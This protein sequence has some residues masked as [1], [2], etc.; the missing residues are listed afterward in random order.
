MSIETLKGKAKTYYISREYIDSKE[1]GRIEFVAKF[2]IERI[3]EL[4]LDDFVLGT[5][6]ESFCYWLEFKKIGGKVILFG[7]GGG[8]ASKFG[9]YKSKDGSYQIGHGEEKKTLSGKELEEYFFSIKNIIK[10]AI[11]YVSENRISEIKKMKMPFDNIVLL[12]ILSIYYPEKFITIGASNVLID[13]AK[14]I[15]LQDIELGYNNLI[16]INYECKKAIDAIPEFKDWSYEKIGTF[17]WDH[18]GNKDTIYY[19]LVGAYWDGSEPDDQ[20]T[21]FLENGIWENG[22]DDKFKEEVNAVP[23]GSKI[24]I[25]A[26]FTKEKTKS[27][28][29]IKAIGTV[30]E[31][32]RDGKKLIVKWDDNFKP[33]EVDFSGGYWST[34]KKVTNK[35]H[36]NAIFHSK[37]YIPENNNF[38]QQLIMFLEQAKTDNLRTNNYVSQYLGT[39]VKVSFGI[40]GKAK[41]PWISFLKGDNTTSKGI[42]PVYLYYKEVERLI[43]AYGISE[44]NTPMLSWNVPDKK[45]IR[46]FYQT[47]Y[48]KD[49]FRYGASYVY[50]VYNVNNLPSAETINEDLNQIIDQYHRIIDNIDDIIPEPEPKNPINFETKSFI[51]A[52]DKSG[53]QYSEKL[54]T[55]FIASLLTKP[56]LILTGLSGSGKTKLAQAFAQWICEDESQ[57]KLIP[58]GADWTNR[59]PLLGYPNSLEPDKYVKPDSDVL[60][61]IIQANKQPS[62]PHF[63]ILDEMNLSIVERY[64]AD[65]LSVMESKKEIPLFPKGSVNNGVP[66]SLG[67]PENLFIIGTVNID[68]TTNMFSPKVLDRANTIEFRVTSQEMQA[69]LNSAS[70]IDMEALTGKGAASAYSFLKMA[71]NKWSSPADIDTIKETLIQFFDELKKTGAEFGYRSAVEILRLIHHLSVL[72]NS[73]TTNDKMDI[74]IMQKLLPKLHGSRR[75]ICPILETLGGF[76]LEENGNIVKDVFEKADFDYDAQEVLYPLSLEK[77]TRMYRGAVENGFASF[78]EA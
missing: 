46:D 35:D 15:N 37:P 29:N 30:L 4:S 45:T 60:D 18:F 20:T 76:C 55:R 34:I 9:L 59:E 70:E 16:E 14:D 36:I 41:I 65:F 62:L 53:L 2:P 47:N 1:K 12:K 73:F 78:A 33:F 49:P 68:E 64:F 8:S 24:A 23:V 10:Q 69:F 31:N 5:D 43:L 52:L 74:A 22:Y 11:K 40:G 13:I 54:I 44:T 71:T 48:S 56:F 50:K 57:Y 27:V 26:A 28:M 17:L 19:F 77:I 38:Y 66:A 63:L 61:L 7:I 21:R 3:S 72:D 42:Y 67:I 58:V 6:K 32:F 51:E 39:K 75:K 25:K